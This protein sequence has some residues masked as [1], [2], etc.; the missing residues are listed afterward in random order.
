MK[1]EQLRPWTDIGSFS[2]RDV[3][4]ED[5]SLIQHY[6][7]LAK[8]LLRQQQPGLRPSPGPNPAS[9]P[10]IDNSSGTHNRSS[11]G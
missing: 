2:L 10:V 9:G 11:R 8:Q 4:A 3:L 5:E 7:V 1:Q 6:E